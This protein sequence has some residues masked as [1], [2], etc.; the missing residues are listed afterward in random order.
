MNR[1]KLSDLQKEEIGRRKE[2]LNENQ[3]KTK[4]IKISKL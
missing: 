1:K 3:I 2:E 4:K